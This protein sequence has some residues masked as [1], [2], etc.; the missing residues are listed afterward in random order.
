MIGE[1]S[2]ERLLYKILLL[3][4]IKDDYALEF[5]N[6]SI[7]MVVG[8]VLF[9]FGPHAFE[10]YPETFMYARWMDARIWALMFIFISSVHLYGL[11][12]RKKLLR[13]N[14][15][16]AA[17]TL[18]LWFGIS[19]WFANKTAFNPYIY[20]FFMLSSFR[21]YLCIQVFNRFKLHITTE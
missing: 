13:K 3:D 7:K 20:F 2:I 17:G 11:V 8:W 12:K 1:K 18:W 14:S 5:Q 21:C 4:Y 16:L 9:I 10:K 15:L 19:I 6:A